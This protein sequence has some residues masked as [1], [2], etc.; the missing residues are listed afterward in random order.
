MQ[1]KRHPRTSVSKARISTLS[2]FYTALLCK[3][4]LHASFSAMPASPDVADSDCDVGSSGPCGGRWSTWCTC[5]NI[6]KIHHSKDIHELSFENSP[7]NIKRWANV[8]LLLEQRRRRYAN[9]K[10]AL[11]QRLMFAER[12]YFF[13]K[14]LHFI[15]KYKSAGLLFD[16]NLNTYTPVLHAYPLVTG[17]L[18]A[19]STTRR[20]YSPAAIT[21]HWTYRTHRLSGT[22]LHLSQVKHVR[23]KCLA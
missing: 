1:A 22:Y 19:I 2:N 23:V 17:R 21:A 20:P 11:A 9:S 3:V 8:V 5:N 6:L 12:S 15:C 4:G 10:P 16:K 7:A 14:S 18:C 13:L